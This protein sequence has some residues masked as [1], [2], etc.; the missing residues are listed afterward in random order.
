VD[1][2]RLKADAV[3]GADEYVVDVAHR[4]SHIHSIMRILQSLESEQ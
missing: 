4:R 2:G 3:Q 1:E